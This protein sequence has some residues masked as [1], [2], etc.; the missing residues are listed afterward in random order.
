MIAVRHTPIRSLPIPRLC[1]EAVK[2]AMMAVSVDPAALTPEQKET[3]RRFTRGGASLLSAPPGWKF[4]GVPPGQVTVDKKEVE[5]LVDIWRGVNSMVGRE[6][7]GVRLFNVSSMLS[8]LVS[9]PEG[10]PVAL[11]LVNYS[12]YPV[13]HVTV[14]LLEKF[15]QARLL[16]PGAA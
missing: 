16:A 14:H 15:S 12:D 1:D 6:N 7:L 4:P 3:L 8:E 10:R 11:H 13:E 9:G 2:G 5:R